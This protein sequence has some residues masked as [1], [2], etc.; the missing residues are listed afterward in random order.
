MQRVRR[1]RAG[2]SDSFSQGNSDTRVAELDGK[3]QSLA[4]HD[5]A[6]RRGRAGTDRGG[7]A[8]VGALVHK[9]VDP[10]SGQPDSKATPF[11]QACCSG[12]NG[13]LSGMIVRLGGK[14]CIFMPSP[15]RRR[16]L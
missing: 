3:L 14:S 7:R 6:L 10:V 8:R 5:E 4:R 11:S 1:A 16:T 12:V 2:E 13:A 15:S 9:I